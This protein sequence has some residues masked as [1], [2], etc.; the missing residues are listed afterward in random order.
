VGLLAFYVSYVLGSVLRAAGF[1]TMLAALYAS[2]YVLLRSEDM[3][4]LLGAILL[5]GIL[6]AIMI[7]TRRVDW[8]R[9]GASAPSVAASSS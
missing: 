3:A 6:A 2:L 4:L 1:A 7:V 5:F 8:N 9:I